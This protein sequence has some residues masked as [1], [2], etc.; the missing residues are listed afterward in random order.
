MFETE[1]YS[2]ETIFEIRNLYTWM[3]YNPQ[4]KMNIGR[5]AYIYQRKKE[6]IN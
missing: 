5:M 4:Y 2:R 6:M 1:S 3:F